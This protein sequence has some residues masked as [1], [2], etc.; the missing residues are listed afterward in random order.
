MSEIEKK[1]RQAIETEAALRRLLTEANALGLFLHPAAPG[2]GRWHI[3]DSQGVKIFPDG[4]GA[5]AL[6]KVA[7]YID[8]AW[9]SIKEDDWGH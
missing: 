5:V 8:K 2:G 4:A 1:E 9:D 3:L 6:A 7:A